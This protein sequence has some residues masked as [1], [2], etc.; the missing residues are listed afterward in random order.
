MENENASILKV[1]GGRAYCLVCER[2]YT[3]P[4]ATCPNCH[5]QTK[6]EIIYSSVML[7]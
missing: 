6:Q 5:A 7:Q 4:V 2:H 1:K 3:D